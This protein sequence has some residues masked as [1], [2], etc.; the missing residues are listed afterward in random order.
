MAT[1]CKPGD[2]AVILYDE[3]ECLANV[4]RLV[5][6][7]PTLQLNLDLNLF[8]WLIEPLQNDPWYISEVDGSI[9]VKP[10]NVSSQVEHPDVWML[11]IKDELPGKQGFTKRSIS[12]PDSAPTYVMS[13][14]EYLAYER[15]QAQIDEALIVDRSVF[16]LGSNNFLGNDAMPHILGAGL[17][18][19]EV[20]YDQ[21]CGSDFERGF[22]ISSAISSFDVG[23]R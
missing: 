12:E 8:C 20:G 2:I 5:R 19:P 4:G 10:I 21:S 17:L 13:E 9:T 16:S 15:I 14:E 11:P 18:R 6:V 1:R 23:S 3:P 22:F 7:H